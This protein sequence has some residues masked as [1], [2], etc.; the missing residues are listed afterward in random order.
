M[1]AYT[2]PKKEDETDIEKMHD[3][4]EGL[5]MEATDFFLSHQPSGCL[6]G[7]PFLSPI[8]IH[9][10]SSEGWSGT[11]GQRTLAGTCPFRKRL[12][13]LAGDGWDPWHMGS[14][15]LA[16]LEGTCQL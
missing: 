7:W 2:V 9:S 5:S 16:M 12:L 10:L 15:P 4:K 6:N 13:S 14:S 8:R 11:V 3:K 1:R